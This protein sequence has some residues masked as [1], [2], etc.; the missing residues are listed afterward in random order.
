MY[1]YY[2]IRIGL[3]F[4]VQDA[5][6][7]TITETR[8]SRIIQYAMTDPDAV[9]LLQSN[10]YR[11]LTAPVSVS[12]LGTDSVFELKINGQTIQTLTYSPYHWCY[13]VGKEGSGADETAKG[14]ALATYRY[15]ESARIYI[16][17]LT[18]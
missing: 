4:I 1:Y 17:S 10:E 15:G 2:C 16:S 13:T 14:L 8:G 18:S 6:D 12:E 5:G 9:T 7:V 3:H 11:L